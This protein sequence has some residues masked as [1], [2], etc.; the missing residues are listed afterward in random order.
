MFLVNTRHPF[1]PSHSLRRLSE[2]LLPGQHLA[3]RLLLV[4]VQCH[5][6]KP[7]SGNSDPFASLHVAFV[8]RISHPPTPPAKKSSSKLFVVGNFTTQRS[9]IAPKSS[10]MD[11]TTFIAVITVLSALL[12][13][14]ILTS[15]SLFVLLRRR[16][17]TQS[18]PSTDPEAVAQIPLV[19]RNAPPDGWD[20]WVVKDTF[21]GIDSAVSRYIG[22]WKLSRDESGVLGDDS[23]SRTEGLLFKEG[24]AQ[25]PHD[26]GRDTRSFPNQRKYTPKEIYSLL[27]NESTRS[28]IMHHI[29]MSILLKAVSLDG[30]PFTSLLPFSPAELCGLRRLREALRGVELFNELEAHIHHFGAYH[31]S[32]PAW[33]EDIQDPYIDFFDSLF[34]PYF[35]GDGSEAKFDRRS[36]LRR[37]LDA[38]ADHGMKAIGCPYH[39][40]QY[41]WGE[42][43]VHNILL[44][45]ELSAS[46]YENGRIVRITEVVKARDV[47]VVR[48][49]GN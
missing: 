10:E 48:G 7:S 25:Q 12:C 41:E 40:F 35:K 24:P 43:D 49:T 39:E 2:G 19:P 33:A 3:Y 23:P 42:R 15:S 8:D 16:S 45:P 30:S 38:A 37:I 21:T 27:Q 22:K 47:P 9:K 44:Y 5:P 28:W 26:E 1:R 6:T 29:F 4:Q 20:E 46:V 17:R 18:P 13:I 34:E 31:A 14:F 32:G 11:T 36:D